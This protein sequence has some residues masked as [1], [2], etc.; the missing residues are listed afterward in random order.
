MTLQHCTTLVW[1][2]AIF[3]VINLQA[4]DCWHLTVM[5]R[6]GLPEREEIS[7][8][9]PYYPSPTIRMTIRKHKPSSWD[10]EIILSFADTEPENG[11]VRWWCPIVADFNLKSPWLE[12][13][14]TAL[15]YGHSLN[16][17]I[18]V[19]LTAYPSPYLALV[20]VKSVLLVR[21]YDTLG[22]VI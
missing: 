3:V 19:G 7:T 11:D 20:I 4:N 6:S 9:F 21:H 18:A 1:L 5:P 2:T 16:S 15:L 22:L 17:L 12:I 8:S 10:R 13:R 14:S